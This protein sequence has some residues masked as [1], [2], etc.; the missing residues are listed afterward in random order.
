MRK[1]FSIIVVIT[2]SLLVISCDF[3]T[4]SETTQTDSATQTTLNERP[5]TTQGPTS[6]L[7]TEHL[8]TTT[9]N[10]TSLITTTET[11]TTTEETT[12]IAYGQG[13]KPSGYT[14]LQDEL[15]M[16]G[17]PSSGDVDV[18]VFA[19]DFSDYPS[20]LNDV[21]IAEIDRVFNGYT[22][23]LEF[24]SVHSFYD[25]SSFGM[26]N[27][28]ADVFGFYRA[29][30]PS[31]YYEDEYE[32]LWAQDPLTGEWL[33]GDDEV[34]YPESDLI[35]EIL[36]YYD[37][38]IDYSQYDANDDGYIDGVY[39]VYTAPVSFASGSDLWWAYQDIYI[40]ENDTFDGVE[41]LY[42]TWAG[43]EFIDAGDN[44]LDARTFIHETGHMLGLDDYYDYSDLDSYNEGGLGGADMM[45]S[46]YGD[47][48]PFSKIL[49]GWITPIVVEESSMVDLSSYA[50]SGDV[51]LLID[52]WQNTIFDEYLLIWFYRPEGLYSLP[53]DRT[54]YFDTPGVVI[55]HVSAPIGQGY[56][57]ELYYYSIFNHNNT[58]TNPKLIKYIEADMNRSIEQYAMTE[59]S[60]LFKEGDIF[61]GNIYSNYRW[62]NTLSINMTVTILSIS[63][64]K[65]TIVIDVK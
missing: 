44:I 4:I 12:T 20:Q 21:S 51:I 17:I 9:T 42:F 60:D 41:P 2:I 36:T 23:D 34:T 28:N 31:S 5:S 27:L 3:F 64:D 57:D 15:D 29:S 19:V 30:Q 46:A 47:H 50:L 25:K 35:Y 54:M 10:E 18:L 13:F 14:L 39:I 26:L 6:T 37:D 11:S 1:L 63:D 32:K 49:L 65:T 43:T 53:D 55:M 24:E 58:D 40:Y 7:S 56:N 45:D 48:G 16:I 38:V 22:N 8:T 61:G 62:Y 33:Y 59:D 52:D